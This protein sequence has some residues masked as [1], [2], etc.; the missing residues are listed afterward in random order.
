M[1]AEAF[2]RV[3]PASVSM[4]NLNENARYADSE[5][6]WAEQER[7]VSA[8]ATRTDAD[9]ELGCGDGGSVGKTLRYPRKLSFQPRYGNLLHPDYAL[10]YPSNACQEQSEPQSPAQDEV[11][12]I[13]TTTNDNH[14]NRMPP[15]SASRPAYTPASAVP[16][17]K[18]CTCEDVLQRPQQPHCSPQQ[19]ER[20]DVAKASTANSIT[21]R[22]VSDVVTSC[23][24]GVAPE[25][26]VSSSTC[27]DDTTAARPAPVVATRE[28]SVMTDE[29][30]LVAERPTRPQAAESTPPAP[31][32]PALEPV[33]QAAFVSPRNLCPL[34]PPT[35]DLCACEKRIFGERS[36]QPTGRLLYRNGDAGVPQPSAVADREALLE[37]VLIFN[38]R[39]CRDNVGAVLRGRAAT[40]DS[41]AAFGEKLRE[42]SDGSAPSS[43]RSSSDD[44]LSGRTSDRGAAIIAECAK[45]GNRFDVRAGTY[46]SGATFENVSSTSST[47]GTSSS[48]TADSS[49]SSASSERGA[50]PPPSADKDRKLTK[51]EREAIL[52]ELEEIISGDLFCAARSSTR[53]YTKPPSFT[54]SMLHL[55]LN[56]LKGS[57]DSDSSASDDGRRR[58]R[59]SSNASVCEEFKSGR[60]A[61]LTRHFSGLG[62][63]G[64]IKAKTKSAPNIGV[65]DDEDSVGSR[66]NYR[67]ASMEE[68]RGRGVTLHEVDDDSSEARI[69]SEA[70]RPSECFERRRSFARQDTVFCKMR[71]VDELD[72]KRR[73]QRKRGQLYRYASVSDF[74]LLE[75]RRP[76]AE[77]GSGDP[78]SATKKIVSFDD[79]DVRKLEGDAEGA[80]RDAGFAVDD[81]FPPSKFCLES[82]L[83]RHRPNDEA[84]RVDYERMTSAIR[85]Y[86]ANKELLLE[87]MKSNSV[88]GFGAGEEG[89]GRSRARVNR[90]RSDFACSSAAGSTRASAAPSLR[91]GMSLD[92][93]AEAPAA[94]RDERDDFVL[95][96]NIRRVYKGAGGPCRG[97]RARK[98][99]RVPSRRSVTAYPAGRQML[100]KMRC[101]SLDAGEDSLLGDGDESQPSRKL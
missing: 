101:L 67:S 26:D 88:D 95:K 87:R 70:E 56:S 51:E 85:D 86:L 74:R 6:R 21:K 32:R 28:K 33:A 20:K 60:V 40:V 27:A 66:V 92:A 41:V 19:G 9:C 93:I 98:W 78:S 91:G 64:I 45:C 7:T 57:S 80:P 30:Y 10:L 63:A 8:G 83:R 52:K 72:Q 13:L 29:A 5:F 47:T 90:T 100:E 81:V 75:H 69:V 38:E 73:R 18:L 65:D 14:A 15:A 89:D 79:L 25:S 76:R 48:G 37:K 24:L 23:C 22:I 11:R 16:Y 77:D 46:F 94:G 31:E 39:Y 2:Q 61:E 35:D 82:L 53:G 3:V 44:N 71:S 34:S 4:I 42:T 59:R 54:S 12:G 99:R 50:Q 17:A 58:R 43:R 96:D 84:L 55:D 62:E 49:T 68:L 97:R 36:D 1:F